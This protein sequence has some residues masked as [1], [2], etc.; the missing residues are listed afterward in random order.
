MKNHA[1]TLLLEPPSLPSDVHLL[2]Y[3][4]KVCSKQGD[5][6]EE[7]STNSTVTVTN[8]ARGSKYTY[9]A[10]VKTIAH[11]I[12]VMNQQVVTTEIESAFASDKTIETAYILT[13]YELAKDTLFGRNV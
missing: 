4:I 2:Y 11:V 10:K 1:F 5:C 6:K 3:I 13:E 7:T 12:I 9:S 8:V